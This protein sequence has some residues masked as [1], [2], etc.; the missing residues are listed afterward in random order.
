MDSPALERGPFVSWLVV[1]PL[2]LA[3]VAPNAI[4]E[5]ATIGHL[6]ALGLASENRQINRR[7]EA[8]DRNVATLLRR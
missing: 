4:D 7:Y 8:R 2:I 1:E 5:S 6:D 3:M